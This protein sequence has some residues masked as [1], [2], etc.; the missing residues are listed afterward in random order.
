[1]EQSSYLVEERPN[2]LPSV[3]AVV[4]PMMRML[5][6]KRI[7]KKRTFPKIKTAPFL[8]PERGPNTPEQAKDR[9][10]AALAMF[11]KAIRARKDSGKP[12]MSGAF[13]EVS[14]EDYATFQEIHTRHH[15][16]QISAA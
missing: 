14:V 6:F 9:L 5:F 7:L 4:R 8:S 10:T 16:G 1:L 15:C 11:G 3:P 2:E 12:V 13:G